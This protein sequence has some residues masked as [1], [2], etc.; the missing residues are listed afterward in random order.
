MPMKRFA[1]RM[2]PQTSAEKGGGFFS[3]YEGNS[4]L[5]FLII[6]LPFQFI[7]MSKVNKLGDSISYRLTRAVKKTAR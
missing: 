3:D 6:W 4:I 1:M 5:K 7:L 2:I